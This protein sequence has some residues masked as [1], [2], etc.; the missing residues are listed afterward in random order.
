[1]KK[2][3][4]FL[5]LLLLSHLLCAQWTSDGVTMYNYN[6]GNVGISTNAPGQRL[7]I[8]GGVR[9]DNGNAFNGIV[10]SSTSNTV[11]WLTFGSSGSGE[12]IG[13]TRLSGYPNINGLDFYSSYTIRMSLTNSGHLLI[14]K[15]TQANSAYIL[16]VNGNVRAN[17]M[18]VNSTGADFVFDAA[19]QLPAL[20]TVESYIR[21]HH[22]LP[23][24]PSAN[25]MEKDGLNVGDNQTLLLQKIEELTLY[26]IQMQKDN[27]ALKTRIEHLEAAQNVTERP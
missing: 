11:P 14:G 17:Q 3:P 13:S 26:L 12:G 8:Q 23:G 1:M 27:E 21:Q 4:L 6:T 16:D 18:V 22:H 20:L 5:S 24:I 2:L 7:A 9:V 19:Y 15:N 10:S 25:Q